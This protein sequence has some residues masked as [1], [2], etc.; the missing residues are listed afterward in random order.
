VPGA[1][2]AAYLDKTFDIEVDFLP[3]V[4][5]NRVLTVNNL[6][7]AIDLFLGKVIDPGLRVNPGLS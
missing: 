7:E 1:P 4:T 6:P 5:L 2:I 3:E